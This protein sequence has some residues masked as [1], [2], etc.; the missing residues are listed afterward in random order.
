MFVRLCPVRAGD[1]SRAGKIRRPNSEGRRN[2]EIRNP[3]SEILVF[4]R[5]VLFCLRADEQTHA[6]DAAFCVTP[7]GRLA[8]AALPTF[9]LQ[10]AT[11][12]SE[13][14]GLREG[15]VRLPGRCFQHCH[16]PR[17]GIWKR[18]FNDRSSSNWTPYCQCH[19]FLFRIPL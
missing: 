2:S 16:V 9:N 17:T 13:G 3:K 10:P 12:N 6:R 7:V 4:T 14:T 8:L 5:V 15:P 18:C 1:E 19:Y 11:F